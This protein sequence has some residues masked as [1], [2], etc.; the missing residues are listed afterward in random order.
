[1]Q[2]AAFRAWSAE[3]VTEKDKDPAQKTPPRFGPTAKLTCLT[4]LVPLLLLRSHVLHTPLLEVRAAA[5]LPPKIGRFDSDRGPRDSLPPGWDHA[6]GP[7]SSNNSTGSTQEQQR[8][9]TDGTSSRTFKR[10]S[11]TM[12]AQIKEYFKDRGGACFLS[13][14]LKIVHEKNTASLCTQTCARCCLRAAAG[15]TT[16]R[17]QV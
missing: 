17:P 11:M 16:A 14:G 13:C 8:T 1:M 3:T 12:L 15:V 5:Q 4:L 6:R 9:P 7:F 2:H 10:T